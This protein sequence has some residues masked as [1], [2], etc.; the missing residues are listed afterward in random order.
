[1]L[2]SGRPVICQPVTPFVSV[3][4][5]ILLLQSTL[6]TAG[7]HDHPLCTTLAGSNHVD[8]TFQLW[9]MSSILNC[10]LFS[11]LSCACSASASGILFPGCEV[12]LC[13]RLYLLRAE[14][15]V[16]RHRY[17]CGLNHTSLDARVPNYVDIANWVTTS[18]FICLPA[19]LVYHTSW[20]QCLNA[21]PR[22]TNT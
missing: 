12:A 19:C 8:C 2:N 17:S 13:F 21:F 22:G 4:P 18:L 7:T 3:M 5:G 20:R 14:H 9:V 16:R 11:V 1:M 15:T 6:A 10:D